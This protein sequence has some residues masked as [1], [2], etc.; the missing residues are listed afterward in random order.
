MSKLHVPGSLQLGGV[1]FVTT[2]TP[3]T[4]PGASE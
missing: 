2:V 4:I 1:C 3:F